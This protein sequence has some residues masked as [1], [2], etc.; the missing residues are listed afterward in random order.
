MIISDTLDKK[1]KKIFQKIEK[2]IFHFHKQRNF[3][4][5]DLSIV[6]EKTVQEQ[7]KA[8]R[9]I[10][11]VTDVLSM[12]S[13]EK[14]DLPKQKKD[15]QQYDFNGRKVPLGSVLICE[16]VAKRQ[17]EEYGHSIERELG[18]LFCHSLLHLLGYDHIEEEDMKVM[19]KI[20]DEIMNKVGLKR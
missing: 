19:F 14:I 1:L 3:F 7:N 6:D 9:N 8:L 10:D 4:E 2:E 18:F 5:I 11:K 15:F 20:Q 13:F 12:P 16:E 17:A